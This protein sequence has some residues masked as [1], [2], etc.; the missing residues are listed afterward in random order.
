ER[1]ENAVRCSESNGKRETRKQRRGQKY[2]FFARFC[3]KKDCLHEHKMNKE[4][5]YHAVCHGDQ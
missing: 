3:L 1:N 2:F 4:V 5:A